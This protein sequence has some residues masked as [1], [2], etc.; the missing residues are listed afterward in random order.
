M[1]YGTSHG[2]LRKGKFQGDIV[3][4]NLPE[5]LEDAGLIFGETLRTLEA[6]SL[7]RGTGIS[8]GIVRYPAVH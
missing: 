2:N 7:V 4:F 1:L 5:R 6:E 8:Y 3:A